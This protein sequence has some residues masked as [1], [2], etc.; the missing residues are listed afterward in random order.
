LDAAFDTQQCKQQQIAAR[1]KSNQPQTKHPRRAAHLDERCAPQLERGR[2]ARDVLDVVRL[3]EDDNVALDR[4]AHRAPDDRVDEVGVGPE[5]EVGVGGPLARE[6]VRACAPRLHRL[7]KGWP[8]G[9]LVSR[10]VLELDSSV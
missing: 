2:F 5:D 6:V 1:I 7:W 4:H 10:F 8:S 3:V 9:W